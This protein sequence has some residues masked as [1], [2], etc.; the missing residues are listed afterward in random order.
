MSHHVWELSSPAYIHTVPKFWQSAIRESQLLPAGISCF[1]RLMEGRHVKRVW[2]L[3]TMQIST[4]PMLWHSASI[5]ESQ[6]LLVIKY[7]IEQII[8][9]PV[10]HLICKKKTRTVFSTCAF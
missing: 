3:S 1:A 4:V 6:L 2:E 7:Q 10:L 9:M 5:R 8:F